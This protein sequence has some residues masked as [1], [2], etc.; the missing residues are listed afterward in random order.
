MEIVKVLTYLRWREKC[1]GAMEKQAA[2]H[3]ISFSSLSL[4]LCL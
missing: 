3:I 1:R 4:F 2:S